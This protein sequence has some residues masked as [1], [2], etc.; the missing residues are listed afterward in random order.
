MPVVDNE[1]RVFYP[2][3]CG[4]KLH[5]CLSSNTAATIADRYM[6]SKKSKSKET[7]EKTPLFSLI[8]I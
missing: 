1:A 7:I 6:T 8:G 4:E 3:N 2:E 5:G